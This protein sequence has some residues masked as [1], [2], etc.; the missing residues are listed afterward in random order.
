VISRDGEEV[1]DGTCLGTGNSHGAS[2][3]TYFS[4]SDDSVKMWN[5]SGLK[6]GHAGN[7]VKPRRL[8]GRLLGFSP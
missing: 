5:D 4:E 6:A 3:A 7:T 2:Q 8:T 1:R